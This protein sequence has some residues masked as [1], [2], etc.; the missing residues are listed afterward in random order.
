MKQKYSLH[1]HPLKNKSPVFVCERC[2][3]IFMSLSLDA[4][5]FLE[6]DQKQEEVL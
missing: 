3:K 2:K 6:F 4:F 5:E 1:R